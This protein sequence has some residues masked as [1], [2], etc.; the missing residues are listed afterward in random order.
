MTEPTKT[1]ISLGAGTQ[2][3]TMLLKS[4]WGELPRVDGAI[5]A[6]TGAEPQRVYDVLD[7]LEREIAGPAGIPIYRVS[8]GN[9]ADDLLDPDR[10][11]MIPAYTVAPDG[12]R[13]MQGR[14]CTQNYKLRKILDKVREELGAPMSES[15]CRHCDATGERVAP[16]RAKRGEEVVGVCS[17][18]RGSKVVRKV[19]QPPSGVWAQQWVGFTT[20]EITRVS[21]K[22][23]TRYARSRYPLIELGMTRQQCITYLR[24]HGWDQVAKSACW[25][26]PYHGNA[27]WRRMRDTDPESWERAV[28]FDEAYRTGAGLKSQRFLHISGQPLR[29]APIDKV[30]RRDLIQL[31]VFDAAFEERLEDGDPDGCSPWGCRSGE[32]VTP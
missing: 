24:H 9:L 1:F 3:V 23:D 29:E 2:S 21:D 27:E 14:P 31:D 11:A 22:G 12:K 10:M 8:F 30:Q 5:F 18:C 32:P 25:M 20:D 26:C 13:G 4:A 19:R 6:D 7:R 28:A 16:W 15:P 17:V